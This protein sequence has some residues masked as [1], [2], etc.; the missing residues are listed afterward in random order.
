MHNKKISIISAVYNKEKEVGLFLESL[1]R[2]TYSKPFEIILVDDFSQDNTSAVI[3]KLSNRKPKH[4][5]IETIKHQTNQGNCKSRNDGIALATADIIIITDADCLLSKNFI[6]TYVDTYEK[7]EADVVVSDFIELEGRDPFITLSR[8]ENNNE[9]VKKSR[10]VDTSIQPN[11][12]LNSV[13]RGF[14][15]KKSRA[16][17]PLY[18][19]HFS[20][21]T[22]PESGFGWEDIEVGCKLYKDGLKFAYANEAFSLHITHAPATNASQRWLKSLK[23][24]RRLHE[25]HPWLAKEWKEW[26]IRSY[27]SILKGQIRFGHF[28]NHDNQVLEK[29]LVIKNFVFDWGA[30][31]LSLAQERFNIF[32]IKDIIV[33]T[34]IFG[35]RDIL[36]D[37]PRF[38]GV[39]YVCFTD[40]PKLTSDIWHIK[41]VPQNHESPR[42]Q[43]KKYKI[44]PHLYF[45]EADY[46]LWVDG[47]HIPLQHP[48]SMV[49][50]FLKNTDISL[51]KHHVRDCIYK[52]AEE[53]IS[54]KLD[55]EKIIRK[56]VASY[57]EKGY[58]SENGLATCTI[59]LRKHSSEKVI[60]AMNSWWKEISENSI[61]DQ[62]SFDYIMHSHSLK[63]QS[64]GNNVYISDLFE[65]F[66]HVNEGKKINSN[67]HKKKSARKAPRILS[68]TRIKFRRMERKIISFIHISIGI[69]GKYIQSI[70]PATHRHLKSLYNKFQNQL[71]RS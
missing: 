53:C 37:P 22:S 21:T 71:I 55:D 32:G 25:K 12:F 36:R 68:L 38:K 49:K 5:S 61:R 19:E 54:R 15:V 47:T 70:S 58:P 4:I 34:A 57:K 39:S 51:F 69:V 56:Q 10:K 52:E 42:K 16:C 26:S 1:F 65:R 28:K 31:L 41:Y 24:Y 14:S 13:T 23:N 27:Y 18:D 29:H 46:S 35:K 7:T 8:Y 20:Y 64:M 48:L 62:I 9:L 6:Q 30:S 44:L 17:D 59:I 11:S 40:D 43:A 63:Y 33:Y 60:G 45:P 2:Q 67:K 50:K 3:E 66:Y